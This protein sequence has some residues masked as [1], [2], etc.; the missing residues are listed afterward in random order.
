MLQHPRTSQQIVQVQTE[1]LLR[2]QV[3]EFQWKKLCAEVPPNCPSK[4][5]TKQKNE[6]HC[7]LCKLHSAIEFACFYL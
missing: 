4:G 6:K 7:I 2:I 5:R 3:F 1:V